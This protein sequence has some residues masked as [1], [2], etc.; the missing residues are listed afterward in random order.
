MGHQ[1]P[2][3]LDDIFVIARGTKEEHT[4]KGSSGLTKLE[5]EGYKGSKKKSNYYQ[6]ERNLAWTRKVT[7]R[8][9]TKRRKNR[10]NKQ[11]RTPNQHQ[12]P[13]IFSGAIQYFAKF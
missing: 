6:K 13:K 11:T 10:R 1:T 7:G 12:N 2:V 5:N 9:Q 4:R 8:N 3:W